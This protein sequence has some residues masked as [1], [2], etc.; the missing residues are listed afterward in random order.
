MS[1]HP[2]DNKLAGLLKSLLK[3]VAV[4]TKR[5]KSEKDRLA[6]ESRLPANEV[7][8][9]LDSLWKSLTPPPDK[10]TDPPQEEA[11]HVV[12]LLRDQGF[13]KSAGTLFTAWGPFIAQDIVES[14]RVAPTLASFKAWLKTAKASKK[15]VESELLS[16]QEPAFRTVGGDWLLANAKLEKLDELSLRLLAREQRPSFLPS[17]EEALAVVLKR[18]KRGALLASLLRNAK[19]DENCLKRMADAIRENRTALKVAAEVLPTLISKESTAARAGEL[20]LAIFGEV[21]ISKTEDRQILT[22]TLARIATGL[23]L[24]DRKSIHA[25]DLFASVSG[26]S[27][28]LRLTTR[29][30][31]L[32]ARTWVFENLQQEIPKVGGLQ[33]TTEGM[34][35]V[36][37]AIEKTTQ[38]FTAG[39]ILATL[40]ENLGLEPVGS[41]GESIAYD[42]I[43]H[44]DLD[45]GLLPGDP[46]IVSENGWAYADSVAIRAKVRRADV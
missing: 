18:D 12:Q 36:A 24:L 22:V 26:L 39:D 31:D 3:G 45:G 34:R 23:L 15:E 8:H 43:R 16:D 30:T 29:E 27:R 25:D 4:G 32:Q 20:V 13:V 38:G 1:T 19:L 10:R 5:E 9:V 41:A 37:N 46:A 35:H 44:Q 21:T 6:L 7:K 17:C 2:S 14:V 11:Q 42:P 40:A 33:V 28:Q